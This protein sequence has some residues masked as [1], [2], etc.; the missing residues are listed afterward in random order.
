MERDVATRVAVSPIDLHRLAPIVGAG[1]VEELLEAAAS[2]S[3]LLGGRRIVNVNST[4]FGGGVA[5][6]LHTLVGY[7][8]GAG[9]ETDW[10]VIDG[11][12][13]FFAVT[14]R[15]HNGLYGGPGDGGELG[16]AEHAHYD[17]VTQ[18]NLERVRPL[19]RPGDVV[20]VHDPQ[21]AGL[22]APLVELGAHVIWRCHVGHDGGNE[23]TE[24]AWG[25]V[26]RYV[27][28][29]HAFVF[30]REPFAPSWSDRSSLHVIPP[31]IDPF[32]PKNRDLRG[33]EVTGLLR[34]AGLLAG[35]GA[36]G[37]PRVAHVATVVRDGLPL[38]ALVP[39][40]VQVS[41][42]DRMKDMS[43]VLHGF[44]E[45]V[46]AGD[47]RLVL[48]GPETDGVDDDPEGAEVWREVLSDWERLP[49]ADRARVQLVAIP[50]ADPV[51]NALV[52]NA[53]QRHAAVVVQKSLAEGFGLTVTEAMWKA[54]PVVAGAVGGIVDQVVD[55]ETGL[56]VDPDDLAAFGAAVGR[57]LDDPAEADA[58]GRNGRRR[59]EQRF[60]GD[61][62][63]L[64]Y[65]TLLTELVVGPPALGA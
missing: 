15:I 41:R 2:L 4:A 16:A 35:D 65:A 52:V 49:P 7:I 6:M 45:H 17:R 36:P 48:A 9:L 13:E 27:E 31:S 23:W 1:R 29:A 14:K 51:E 39:L 12:P 3:R 40:V 50:M 30:S 10:L 44:A 26:R 55:G 54:R 60:L 64:D 56:L 53:L 43:G 32:A 62:H 34:G 47:A 22:V 8:L 37:D 63:L 21:P 28:P 38:D 61:R 46:P 11:D 42:W 58:L 59:A 19:V 5:E 57:L 24:R 18:R 20:L 33:G 25:F